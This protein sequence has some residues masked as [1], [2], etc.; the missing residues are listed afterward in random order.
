[1][2]NI[3]RFYWPI[4]L[5]FSLLLT[6]LR[7]RRISLGYTQEKMSEI[8]GIEHTKYT[9]IENGSINRVSV[10]DAFIIA[11]ALNA[12]I[13]S[14]FMTNDVHQEHKKPTGGDAA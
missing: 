5:P 14:I 10:D 11:K 9:R 8:T 6:A 3:L 4:F 12:T 1:V 13:G 7:D 2:D